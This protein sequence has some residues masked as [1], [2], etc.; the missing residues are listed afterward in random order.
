MTDH[1]VHY[2][3]ER[4]GALHAFAEPVGHAGRQFTADK[5]KVTCSTCLSILSGG[6]MLP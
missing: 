2:Y 6:V 4:I 1:A 3:V 5:A